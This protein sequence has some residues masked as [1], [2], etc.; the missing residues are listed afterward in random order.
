MG[1][2]I[3][4]VLFIIIV[5]V[6]AITPMIK[7]SNKS[8]SAEI[9]TKEM[10]FTDTTI[11]EVDINR[12]QGRAYSISGVRDAGV[13]TLQQLN[14]HTDKIKLLRADVGIFKGDNIYLDHNVIV[15]QKQG[16]DYSA[17]H[18]VYNQKT[19]ILNVTSPFAAY[20]HDNIIFGDTLEYDTN[21]KEA[22][23]TRIE[24]TIYTAEK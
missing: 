10:E 19:E 17:D 2:R 11:I 1:V 8:V 24:A 15:N 6:L 16:F 14:Y 7:I 21:K 20:I 18:A 12:T 5:A 22:F 13:L 23:A 9:S 4:I 3:E